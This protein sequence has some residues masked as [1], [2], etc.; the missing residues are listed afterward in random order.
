MVLEPGRLAAREAGLPAAALGPPLP[1][2]ADQ[3]RRRRVHRRR[4]RASRR[5]PARAE[6]GAGTLPRADA[7]HRAL[8]EGRLRQQPDGQQ[9][10]RRALPRH[11]ARRASS[12]RSTTSTSAGRATTARTTRRSAASRTRPR[13]ARAPRGSSQRGIFPAEFI[14]PYVH[15]IGVSANYSDEAVHADGLPPRDDL[16][17]RHPVLRRRE[18][19]GHRQPGPPGR[20]QEGDVEGHGR[21]R[22]ADVDPRHQQEDAPSSSPASSSGTTSSTNPGLRAADRVARAGDRTSST[23]PGLV[24]DRRPRPAVDRPRRQRERDRGVSATRSATGSRSSRSRPSP[25]TA[26]AASSRSPAWRSTG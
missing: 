8:P 24:P 3:P 25:S 23:A 12:S 11:D 7:R 13:T 9:P 1:R 19:D 17:H 26:A 10:G 5:H 15:T 14:A 16:R 18:A 21:L 20:H 6:A 4:L 2:S 22:P